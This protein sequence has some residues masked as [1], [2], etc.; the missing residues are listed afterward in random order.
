MKKATVD[1]GDKPL[2]VGLSVAFIWALAGQMLTNFL[3]NVIFGSGGFTPHPFTGKGILFAL[4]DLIAAGLLVF[5]GEA[6]R[7]GRRWSWWVIM[8]LS[9]GLS[10]GGLVLIPST[11]GALRHH[12]VWPL[13]SQLILLTLA[14][15]I[16]Y[17]MIQ[18]PTQRWYERVTIIAARARHNKPRWL[19][20]I[21][22]S[23][24]VGGFLTAL[25]QRLG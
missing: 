17:R 11:I 1:V 7:S 10:V 12:D 19:V 14:P 15:F 3:F 25:F 18:P 16:F 8:V 13:W 24:A 2:G 20:T 21:I 6:L 5:I 4:G 22:G 9:G 23:A